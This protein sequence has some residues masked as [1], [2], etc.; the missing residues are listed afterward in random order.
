MD[1][2]VRFKAL[3]SKQN[4]LFPEDI[5]RRI[6]EDHR[7]RLVNRVVDDLDISSLLSQYKEGGAS[8]FIP[9][10]HLRYCFTAT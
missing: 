6:A 9:E 1:L 10:L 5:F 4:S 8:S 7:V 3:P 2:K